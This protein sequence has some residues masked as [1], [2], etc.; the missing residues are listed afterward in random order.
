[1]YIQYT[2]FMHTYIK[3]LSQFKWQVKIKKLKPSHWKVV[4]VK[5]LRG[6]GGNVNFIICSGS[7]IYYTNLPTIYCF[8]KCMHTHVFTCVC[9]WWVQLKQKFFLPPT[10][11][12]QSCFHLCSRLLS[13]SVQQRH[14]DSY[15][16][17][18]PKWT[19]VHLCNHMGG[20]MSVCLSS[21]QPYINV[22]RTLLFHR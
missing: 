17:V 12:L 7:Y 16:N 2:Y 13:G 21:W 8:V 4:T 20:R 15:L 18:L 19:S 5:P 10:S 3:R 14:S 1:M 22:H 11:Y 6:G 9:V